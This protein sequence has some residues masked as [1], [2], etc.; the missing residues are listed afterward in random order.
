[1]YE[2]LEREAARAGLPLKWPA[3]L[4]NTRTALAAAEWIRRNRPDVSSDFNRRLFA[5]RFAHGEDLG[6]PVV[7]ERYADEVGVDLGA[8]RD[9]LTTGTALAFLAEAESVGARFGVRATP[10]WLIA[11]ESISGLLAPAEFERL[12]EKATSRE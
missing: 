9:A 12:A 10:S 7:I 6:E 3:R 4:P 11:G 1:M 5:A 2:T 8:L